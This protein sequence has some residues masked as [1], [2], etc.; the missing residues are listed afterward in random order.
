[1]CGPTLYLRRLGKTRQ[2]WSWVTNTR[3]EWPTLVWFEQNNILLEQTQPQNICAADT[4]TFRLEQ[5]HVLII[6]A[7]ANII[8]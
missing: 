5:K 1:M 8:N 3:L 2:A 7:N 4:K 6:Q